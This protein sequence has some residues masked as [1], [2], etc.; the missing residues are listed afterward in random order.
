[1]LSSQTPSSLVRSTFLLSVRHPAHTN[2]EIPRIEGDHAV[3]LA[4]L[5]TE[6]RRLL[7]V[8]ELVRLFGAQA[9]SP[10]DYVDYDWG[11]DPWAGGGYAC[12]M[13]PGVLTSFGRTIREPVGSIHWAGTETARN[14]M[15]YFEGAIESGIRA[16]HEVTG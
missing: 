7:V 3:E 15:G 6:E 2:H 5:S 1:M 9:G 8:S 10:I 12:Y 4:D 16:A 14:S 11:R 13:P